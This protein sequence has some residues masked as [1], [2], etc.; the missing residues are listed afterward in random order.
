MCHR[1]S[2][3]LGTYLPRAHFEF[4]QKTEMVGIP[5]LTYDLEVLLVGGAPEIAQ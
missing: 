1:L 4:V 5:V 2:N 3:Y